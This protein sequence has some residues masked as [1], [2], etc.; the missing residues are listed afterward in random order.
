[1]NHRVDEKGCFLGRSTAEDACDESAFFA[2]VITPDILV[3]KILQTID[4][5]DDDG[6][7]SRAYYIALRSYELSDHMPSGCAI[8]I[9]SR[10]SA[11]DKGLICPVLF[12]DYNSDHRCLNYYG[13]AG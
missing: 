1:M 6:G 5:I 8:L 2:V 7:D 10:M 11:A 9:K 3:K 13:T 12:R 4:C